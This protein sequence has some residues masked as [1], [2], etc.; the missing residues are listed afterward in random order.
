[1]QGLSPPTT[2]GR[3]DASPSRQINCPQS[4]VDEEAEELGVPTGLEVEWPEDDVKRLN[5]RYCGSITVP[6]APSLT[7]KEKAH[8]D[9]QGQIAVEQAFT[10]SRPKRVDQAP[11]RSPVAWL[12]AQR[13]DPMY[14]DRRSSAMAHCKELARDPWR[15]GG[16]KQKKPAR[17]GRAKLFFDHHASVQSTKTGPRGV[18]T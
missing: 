3:L 18:N 4:A 16:E 1:M 11:S 7:E 12:Q 10:T 17:I 6:P 14:D 13:T 9:G 8:V 5:F 2:R 15:A